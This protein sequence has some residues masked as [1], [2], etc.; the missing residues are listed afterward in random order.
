MKN[1]GL[2]VFIER[3]SFCIFNVF[4]EMQSHREISSLNTRQMY[5]IEMILKQVKYCETIRICSFIF[6]NKLRKHVKIARQCCRT[7]TTYFIRIRHFG[8][9]DRRQNARSTICAYRYHGK[10]DIKHMRDDDYR[11]IVFF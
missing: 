6:S 5:S 8:H 7:R 9:I 11:A 10:C 4:V 1:L 3:E 2:S